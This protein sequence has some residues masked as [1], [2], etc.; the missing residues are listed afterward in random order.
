[1]AFVAAGFLRNLVYGIDSRDPLTF[2][3]VPLVLILRT[4]PICAWPPV[5]R[6]GSGSADDAASYA[7]TT[8]RPQ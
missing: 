1:V 3:A 6:Y 8:P 5:A 7:C 4:R 2:I